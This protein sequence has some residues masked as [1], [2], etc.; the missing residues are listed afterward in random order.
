MTLLFFPTVPLLP[1]VHKC[2]FHSFS[3]SFISFP[4]YLLLWLRVPHSSP[5]PCPLFLLAHSHWIFFLLHVSVVVAEEGAFHSIKCKMFFKRDSSWSELGIGMLNLKKLEGKTQVLVR[6]DTTL[7]K[8]IL[9]IYLAESTPITRSGKNNVIL[10]CVPNP[11]LYSKPSEG[12]NNKPATYLIRVKT[13]EAADE[14]FSQLNKSKSSSNWY[15][16]LMNN[17]KQW[18]KWKIYSVALGTVLYYVFKFIG[19]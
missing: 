17:S 19:G 6:N 14:L 9:N 2:H 12:D 18:E 13:A 7:G 8:I 11:P 3:P 16:Y 15:F 5:L 10:M 4:F 1:L